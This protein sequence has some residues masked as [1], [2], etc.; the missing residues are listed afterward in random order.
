MQKMEENKSSALSVLPTL[1]GNQDIKND[2]S[3]T[4][5][6]LIDMNIRMQSIITRKTILKKNQ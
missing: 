3:N 4:E 5:R 6:D 1:M 2:A